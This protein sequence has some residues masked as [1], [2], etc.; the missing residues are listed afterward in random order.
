MNLLLTVPLY[1]RGHA[2]AANNPELLMRRQAS[3]DAHQKRYG[4]LVQAS[5]T[6][7]GVPAELLSSILLLENETGKADSVNVRGAIGLGQIKPF[8]ACDMIS[9]AKTKG[10][11]TP[12]KRARI[13]S[14]FAKLDELLAV[15]DTGRFKNNYWQNAITPALKD[16]AFNIDVA[17]L[18][19]S[20]FVAEHS[21]G[22]KLRSDYCA[23]RYNQGYYV[24][25]A[26]KISRSL[27]PD[28]LLAAKIPSEGKNYILRICGVGGWLDVLAE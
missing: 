21:A 16:P 26:N 24:L 20:L 11:L 27:T 3:A 1:N 28:G 15:K 8:V 13:A 6:L 2:E 17:A 18:I 10:L 19:L 9:L 23:L 25:S 5:A 4:S 7:N 12:A 22:G 14:E